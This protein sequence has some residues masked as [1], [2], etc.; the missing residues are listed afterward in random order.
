MFSEE[1]TLL[2]LAWLC[3]EKNVPE[4]LWVLCRG[5]HSSETHFLLSMESEV[6]EEFD[7]SSMD[8]FLLRKCLSRKRFKFCKIFMY[9]RHKQPQNIKIQ[10]QD[11]KLRKL[12]W[13]SRSLR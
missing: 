4:Q 13:D 3:P 8:L 12:F 6:V 11:K 7:V 2:R 9:G 5:R 1:L 10:M